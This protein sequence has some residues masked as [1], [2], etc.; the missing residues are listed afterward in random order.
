MARGWKLVL[1]VTLGCVGAMDICG[2]YCGPTWCSGQAIPECALVKGSGCQTSSQDCK[3]DGPTDGSC[4]DACCKVHDGCCGSSDRRGCNDAIIACLKACPSGP[5]SPGQTCMHG[6]L[7]VPV[8]AILAGMEVDPY[9]CCGTSCD[10]E[11]TDLQGGAWDE[12]VKQA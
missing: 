11:L 3:E 8:D 7:P 1:V 4:A 2:N 10:A 9:K 12:D 6:E 5:G